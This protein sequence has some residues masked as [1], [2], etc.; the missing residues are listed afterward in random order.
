[1]LEKLKI[2]R[3]QVRKNLGLLHGVNLAEAVMIEL[4]T[5]G[6]DRQVA[7]AFVRDA[8]ME[9][10]SGKKSL[11]KVLG[12][13]KEVAALIGEEE[14]ARLLDPDR[15]IGTAVEQVERVIALLTPVARGTFPE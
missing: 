3:D 1:V 4:V 14:I 5:R 13:K 12:K 10:L 9:A 15:Y 6:M 7:H 2:N 11:E 8:S